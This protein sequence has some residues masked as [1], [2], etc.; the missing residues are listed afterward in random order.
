MKKPVLIVISILMIILLSIPISAIESVPLQSIGLS[1][2]GVTLTIGQSCSFGV[3]FNPEN[4]T[5]KLIRYSSSDTTV[6]DVDLYGKI[7]ALKSGTAVVKVFCSMNE[8]VFANCYVTVMDIPIPTPAPTPVS[9][10]VPTPTP[11]PTPAPTPTII[12]YFSEG[13]GEPL[14]DKSF[15]KVKG[16]LAQCNFA[17]KSVNLKAKKRIPSDLGVLVIVQP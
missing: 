4:S 1:I 17:I 3:S 13:H 6:A 9:T 10:P 8:N 14:V 12:V 2:T 16:D 11:T 7:T 15:K 5:Q